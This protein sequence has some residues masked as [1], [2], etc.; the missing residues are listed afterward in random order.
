MEAGGG[1]GRVGTE[2]GGRGR[3]WAVQ[4]EGGRC[5]VSGVVWR[6]RQKVC[7]EPVYAVKHEC[8]H[9]TTAVDCYRRGYSPAGRRCDVAR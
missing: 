5:S 6:Q 4:E 3:A 1:S 8:S 7:V 2:E 9:A